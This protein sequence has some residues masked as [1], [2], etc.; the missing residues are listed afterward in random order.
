[1]ASFW[2]VLRGS[3]LWLAFDLL[4]F[5]LRHHGSAHLLGSIWKAHLVRWRPTIYSLVGVEDQQSLCL[6]F[7]VYHKV[8]FAGL[9]PFLK[10]PT[11]RCLDAIICACG[12][13]LYFIPCHCIHWIWDDV[14]F[15]QGQLRVL[16]S[17]TLR[18]PKCL[19]LRSRSG[20]TMFH[21]FFDIDCPSCDSSLES[22]DNSGTAVVQHNSS[23]DFFN[24]G[25][26]LLTKRPVN[27]LRFL[28]LFAETLSAFL[29]ILIL[30]LMTPRVTEALFVSVP[31]L[32][33][34]DDPSVTLRIT[35]FFFFH[36]WLMFQAW[37]L[38]QVT[39]ALLPWN[40]CS[41]QRQYPSRHG[42]SYQRISGALR[43]VSG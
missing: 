28:V 5:L 22:S 41:L 6:V 1:M 27:F 16:C 29:G 13:P 33:Q 24:S 43:S 19:M 4:C 34:K 42:H 21:S 37:H 18:L 9:I 35:F 36:I 8:S 10:A 15:G 17:K 39:R 2:V 32:R 7:L 23:K 12:F 25:H 30:G 40:L 31:V 20:S 26:F 38:T 14:F 3:L 11:F